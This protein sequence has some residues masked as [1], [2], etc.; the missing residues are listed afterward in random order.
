MPRASVEP[1]R[2]DW[3]AP[4]NVVAFTTTRQ[5]GVSAGP[6]ASLNLAAHVGDDPAAVEENRR[7]LGEAL[8]LPSRPCWLEQVH[9]A[10]VLE[11][12]GIP[13]GAPPRA[14]RADAS[15]TRTPGVV[16]A[17]LTAD[18]LPILLCDEAGTAVAAIHAG[19]RGLAAGVI[20]AAVSRLRS[21]A[22]HW[23]AWLGPAIGKDAY[24]VGDEVRDALVRQSEEAAGAFV[25][26]RAGR[27]QADLRRL[28]RLR[29]EALGVKNVHDCGLCT[30][31]DPERL[32]SHRRDGTC[33]RVA[34]VIWILR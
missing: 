15:I 29:L 25:R 22:T 30:F 4:P 9:G 11:A 32:F 23:L 26:N 18:C 17:V 8:E 27:W 34:T 31:S 5:G 10:G 7:R 21:K 13:E 24:E 19:W 1:I 16:C 12:Q 33:G 28:S 6:Y 14:A 20:E 3:P 2:P